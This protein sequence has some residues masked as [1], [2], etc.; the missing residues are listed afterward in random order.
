MSITKKLFAVQQEIG[1][2]SKDATNPFYK[3]KYFDI[4]SLIEQTIP[5]FKKH[6]ILLLQPIKNGEVYTI[7]RCSETNEQEESSIPLPE[8]SDPQKVGS[9]ITYYRRYNLASLLGLQAED[10]DANSTIGNVTDNRP[11]LTQ[12]GL[13]YVLQGSKED[14][15]KA[16]QQRRM[17]TEYKQLI[18]KK[19]GI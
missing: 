5:L 13:E 16:M 14:A 10:D 7:L 2:I 17:K 9:C 3:S 4:N 19:H 18:Q 1:K 6:G 15:V 11:W 12:E 8:M